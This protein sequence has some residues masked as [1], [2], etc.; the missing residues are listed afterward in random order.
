M[1][2]IN[3][4][5]I[6]EVLKE[7]QAMLTGH[8]E[9]SSGLHSNQYFQCARVLQYPQIAQRIGEKLAALFDS[10]KIDTVV[11]PALG[12]MIIGH[13]VA[14]AL[15]KKS[16]FVERKNGQMQL[17]RGFELKNGERVIIIE[18]VIT[19]AKSALEAADVIRSFGGEVLGYGCIVDRSGGKTGLNIKSLVQ[20]EPVIYEPDNCPLCLS[21]SKAVKPGSRDS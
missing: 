12:G 13:E 9:L 18:D 3:E 14:R 4:I 15:N 10:E 21:G 6:I 17:R 20:I 8:F 2:I 7:T 5:D 19:T 11:G 1:Q 16:I